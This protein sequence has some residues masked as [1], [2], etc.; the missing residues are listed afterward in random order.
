MEAVSHQPVSVGIEADQTAFQLYSR[1]VLSGMCGGKLDHG[2]LLVGY[3]SENGLDYWKVKNSWGAAWGEDGYIRLK[4]GLPKAG[5]CG[6]NSM[7][8]YPVVHGAA[9]ETSILV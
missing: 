5:Q 7:A 9:H 8:S 4:R 6:I 3:G 1:G 2:V